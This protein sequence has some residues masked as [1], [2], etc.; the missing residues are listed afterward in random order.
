MTPE[1]VTSQETPRARRYARRTL[2]W[3][4]SGLPRV[5]K[6]GRVTHN[7]TGQVALRLSNG[8]AGFAGLVTCGS[9]WA[10]P[11]CNSKIMARR[12]M[13]FS[14]AAALHQSKG[15]SLVFTTQTLRHS[16]S[17]TLADLWSVLAYC[18]NATT[19]GAPWL[20]LKSRLGIVGYVRVVEVTYGRNGWHVHLHTL[21]FLT[22]KVTD[23]TA[24]ELGQALYARWRAAAVRK[25]MRAPL[26]IGQDSHLVTGAG[27]AEEVAQYFTKTDH[28]AEAMAWELSHAQGKGSRVPGATVPVWALLDRIRQEGCAESLG[29]WHE[30]ERASKGRR[31]VNWSRGL[32][33]LLALSDEQSD[34]EIAAQEH[35]SSADDLL[36]VLDWSEMVAR[37]HL[38][39]QLL[40]AAESGGFAGAALFLQSH[41]ITYTSEGVSA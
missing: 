16:K 22:G 13:E 4:E 28:G 33:A 37:P 32:R 5:R 2:L 26:P 18:S 9:V 27:A 36:Y 24:R 41:G 23:S 39:P 11:V 35:G 25:G 3:H 6:C 30:Y 1:T 17:D 8:R 14:A 38:I 15:G 10:E 20:R 34:E 21:W 7:G 31:C 29:L 19:T 40:S 12:R